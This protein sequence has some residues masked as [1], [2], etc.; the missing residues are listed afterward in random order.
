MNRVIHVIYENS[1]L[2]P[3]QPI[4]LDE[5]ETYLVSIYREE[6]WRKDFEALLQRIQQRTQKHSSKAIEADITAT[7]A[8]VK[9]KRR[10]AR[11]SH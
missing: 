11:R 3:L 9:A 1:V 8:G 5:R 4:Q 7:R 10:E 6:Q 2:K